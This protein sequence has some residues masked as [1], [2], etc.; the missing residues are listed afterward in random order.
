[1]PPKT[2]GANG[3][4]GNF[5]VGLMPIHELATA[6]HRNMNGR[7]D[8]RRIPLS[9]DALSWVALTVSTS[10]SARLRIPGTGS[11]RW[12]L[13]SGGSFRRGSSSRPGFVLCTNV[14]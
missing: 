14:Q 12:P 1:M 10:H 6:N 2:R 8:Y 5:R 7:G 13:V 11:K 4:L 9:S 3:D